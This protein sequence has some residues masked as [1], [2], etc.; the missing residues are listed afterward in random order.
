[1]GVMKAGGA[2]LPLDPSY[3]QERLRFMVED[4][5]ARVVVSEES[6]R[7]AVSGTGATVVSLDEEAEDGGREEETAPVV[8]V[9]AGHLAY[10]IYTS[11][12][13]G[14]PKGVEVTHGGLRNLVGWHRRAY[15]VVGSDRATMLASLSF[16]ASVWELWPYLTA[17]ASVELLPEEELR[18][19]PKRVMEWLGRSGTT[20]TFLPTPLAGAA[21]REGVAGGL[22]VRA[23][24]SGGDV[25]HAGPGG[26]GAPGV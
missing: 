17:G 6:H 25:L 1:L 5:A 23:L 14:R 20:L 7:E 26:C 4:S 18:L 16:D 21:L 15:E 2:Y 10:V 9:G 13:T 8:H 11:G 3:P 19:S 24:F 22:R 12:S